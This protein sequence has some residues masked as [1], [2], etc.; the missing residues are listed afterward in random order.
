MAKA[1]AIC[2]CK[3]CGKQFEKST[4]KGSRRE[5]DAWEAWAIQNF[6]LCPECY[7]AERRTA[8]ADAYAALVEKYD[9]PEITAVSDKQREYA[10]TLR[11]N[12]VLRNRDTFLIVADHDLPS[13][14]KQETWAVKK[15]IPAE[16]IEQWRADTTAFL[17]RTYRYTSYVILTTGDARTL[18]DAIKN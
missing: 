10:E 18:I 2:T 8:Q 11:R 13:I 12:Y 17:K 5:A 1:T 6:D 7:A 3:H 9:L 14:Q 15:G 16:K 4:T